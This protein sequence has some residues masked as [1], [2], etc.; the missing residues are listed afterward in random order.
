M[1]V[2]AGSAQELKFAIVEWADDEAPEPRAT[3]YPEAISD[4]PF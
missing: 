1:K 4:D 3:E 2:K